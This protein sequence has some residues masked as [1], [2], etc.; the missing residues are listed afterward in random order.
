MF[1]AKNF[2]GITFLTETKGELFR[3]GGD[4]VRNI[5][6]LVEQMTFQIRRGL[7]PG[8]SVFT[9]CVFMPAL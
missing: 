8:L 5:S 3:R 9:I 1:L 4:L 7:R 6:T 2:H